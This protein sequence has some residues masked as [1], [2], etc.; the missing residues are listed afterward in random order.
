MK[1]YGLRHGKGRQYDS[2]DPMPVAR[3]RHEARIDAL[4]AADEPNWY[5]DWDLDGFDFYGDD[6]YDWD[7][8]PTAPAIIGTA[9]LRRSA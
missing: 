6:W 9:V 1:A 8:R 5:C 4:K 7:G 2:I 3:E